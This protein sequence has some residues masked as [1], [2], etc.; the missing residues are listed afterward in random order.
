MSGHDFFVKFRS[1]VRGYHVY[2]RVWT[3][4]LGEHVPYV[5][6]SNIPPIY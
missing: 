3:L 4:V 2:K 6:C 5:H 1:V